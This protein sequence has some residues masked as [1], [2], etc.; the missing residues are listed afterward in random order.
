[1]CVCVCVQ[2]V[3]GELALSSPLDACGG[4]IHN[5]ESLSGAIAVVLRGGGCSFVDKALEV[6]SAGALGM[7][8]LDLHTHV[9]TEDITMTGDAGMVRHDMCALHLV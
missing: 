1:M 4:T 9:N 8:V 7:V 3:W 6:Q 5:S 2:V